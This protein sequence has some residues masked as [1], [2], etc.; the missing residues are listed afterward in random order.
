MTFRLVV[1]LGVIL[2]IFDTLKQLYIRKSSRQTR[3]Y[4]WLLALEPLLLTLGL[5]LLLGI[6]FVREAPA[7]TFVGAGLT[8]CLVSWTALQFIPQNRIRRS[9]LVLILATLA[10]TFSSDEAIRLIWFCGPT[11][12]SG[13]STTLPFFAAI[14]WLSYVYQMAADIKQLKS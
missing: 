8:L 7:R 5:L 4:S 14:F 3:G 2:C 13:L 11:C 10:T 6:Q 9:F 12:Q 1:M